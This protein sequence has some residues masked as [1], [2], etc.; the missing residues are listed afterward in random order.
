MEK[1]VISSFKDL[2]ISS[3]FRF[4]PQENKSPI[5]HTVKKEIK[6]KQSNKNYKEKLKDPRWQRKRL[7]IFNRDGFVCFHCGDDK[8][9][10]H[11]H[12]EMYIGK[13]PWD[14]PDELLTTLCEDCHEFNHIKFS[15]LELL[16]IDAIRLRDGKESF[17][18]WKKI[19]R[20]L[21]GK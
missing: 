5:T 13:D 9:T 16:L 14:T 15:K 21:Y 11:V 2:N 19:I 20:D 4:P 7:E 18:G 8:N 12:H 17:V 10:L 3:G 6:K 1:K